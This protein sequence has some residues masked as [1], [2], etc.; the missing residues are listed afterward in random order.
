M[1]RHCFRPR[2]RCRTERGARRHGGGR[3]PASCGWRRIAVGGSQASRGR[4]QPSVLPSVT[5]RHLG[6]G[7]GST[8]RGWRR[9]YVSGMVA[10]RHLGVGGATASRGWRRYGV[11]KLAAARTEVRMTWAQEGTGARTQRRKNGVG[12]PGTWARDGAGMVPAEAWRLGV[13]SAAA[14]RL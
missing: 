11:S 3:C 4:R 6:D 8:S 13:G 14:R 10:P 7:G 5:P 12:G 1:P 2:C 9:L